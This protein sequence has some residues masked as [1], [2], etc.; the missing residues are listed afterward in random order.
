[1]CLMDPG[2]GMGEGGDRCGSETSP[3]PVVRVQVHVREGEAY[4]FTW[5]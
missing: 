2:I 5:R 3:Q 4:M 1:M